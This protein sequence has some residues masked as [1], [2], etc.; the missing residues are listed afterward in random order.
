MPYRCALLVAALG[1]LC[2]GCSHPRRLVLH[3]TEG[4][5]FTTECSKDSGCHLAAKGVAFRA[6]GRVIGICNVP[7]KR[8]L[9]ASDCRP[10]T[11]KRDTDCPPR[12]EMPHGTCLGGLCIA[13]A[14]PINVDDAVMLC[15]AGTGL[16]RST[17]KQIERYALAENCGTPCKVPAPC[18]QP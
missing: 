1:A 16:G 8:P 6:T 2:A 13:P 18:R 3:D 14:H 9:R 11:C 10:L 5:S 12:H 17:E 7:A 15:L 4:R